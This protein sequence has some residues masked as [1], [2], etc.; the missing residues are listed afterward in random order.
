MRN[1][2]IYMILAVTISTSLSYLSALE[3]QEYEFV[4]SWPEILGLESPSGVAVDNSGNLYAADTINNRINRIQKFDSA[5]KFLMQWGT[6]GSDDGE[7]Y[8]PSG[9]AVDGSG[10]VYIA[11]WTYSPDFPTL[12]P[13]QTDQ[14]SADVFVTKFG[15]DS[16]SIPTLSEWGMLIMMLLLLSG[17]CRIKIK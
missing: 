10:N 8:G 4:L 1:G 7:F 15:P 6:E 17:R 16:E 3:A 14:T 9:I 12:N 13:Y 2:I 11:G 5:G